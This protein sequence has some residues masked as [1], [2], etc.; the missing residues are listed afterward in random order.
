MFQG[1][2]D[3]KKQNPS[4]KNAFRMTLKSSNGD[5]KIE[6]FYFGPGEYDDDTKHFGIGN[7]HIHPNIVDELRQIIKIR[8]TK[9]VDIIADWFS[10][11]FDLDVDNIS[12]Y[13]ER[14]TP[15][16]Y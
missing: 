14:K 11:K 10:E 6:Y 16:I 4:N 13:P 8:E 7:L 1:Y 12:I 2:N 9:V 15:A 5:E 3:E